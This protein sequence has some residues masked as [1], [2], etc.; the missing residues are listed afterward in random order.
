MSVRFVRSLQSTH[1]KVVVV[2]AL[3]RI[4][5]CVYFRVVVCGLPVVIVKYKMSG[6][7]MSVNSGLTGQ[8]DEGFG[9]PREGAIDDVRRI[10][11]DAMHR[12]EVKDTRPDSRWTL[13]KYRQEWGGM[14]EVWHISAMDVDGKIFVMYDRNSLQ[15]DTVLG[16]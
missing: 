9:A 4:F 16:A 7:F 11:A 12:E 10:A 6:N 8:G 5:F 15:P 2:V 14:M 1:P 13:S 3:L